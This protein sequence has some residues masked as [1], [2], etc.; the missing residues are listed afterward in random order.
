MS[1][2][3][4]VKLFRNYLKNLG[5]PD[6]HGKAASLVTQLNKRNFILCYAGADRYSFVHRTFLEYFCAAWFVDAFQRK[7]TMTLD[8]LKDEVF[9]AALER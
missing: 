4:L 7:Q 5:V 2:T 9:G 6:P 3:E 8:Q 1:A